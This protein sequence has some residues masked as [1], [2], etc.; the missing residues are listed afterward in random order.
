M[1]TSVRDNTVDFRFSIPCSGIIAGQSKCGKSTLAYEI[2]INRDRWIKGDV[3][4]IIYLYSYL[5]K[6]FT[7]LKAQDPENVVLVD[8]FE[9]LDENV[10]R[11]SL[12][13]I[14]DALSYMHNKKYVRQITDYFTK[15]VHHENL[16]VL[17]LTQNIFSDSMR[18]ISINSDFLV[19][20][21]SPRSKGTVINIARDFSPGNTSYVLEAYNKAVSAGAHS[22]LIL[23]FR[24]QVPNRFRVRDRIYPSAEMN[25]YVPR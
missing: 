9:S 10:V 24:Q 19:L 23:D 2:V 16:F 3:A 25:I 7:A 11:N 14:D 13:I 18:T 17:F 12:I 15:R 20:F 6:D 5:S 21:N 1:N 22:Y 4:R 8:N